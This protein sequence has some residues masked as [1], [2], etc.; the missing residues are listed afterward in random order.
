MLKR[1]KY[2][3]PRF[4]NSTQTVKKSY[5]LNDFKQRGMA[6]YTVKNLFALLRRITS[7][8]DG[9][10]YFLKCLHSFGT[11]PNLNHVKKYVKKRLLWCENVLCTW[12]VVRVY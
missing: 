7:K 11:K 10:F 12:Y 4:R 5:S 9:D 6:L 8:H 2:I 1:K 3:L